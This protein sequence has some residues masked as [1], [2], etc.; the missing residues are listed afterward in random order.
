MQPFK[1]VKCLFKTI[2][3]FLKR[4]QMCK[5]SSYW[6]LNDSSKTSY[7]LITSKS[8][9][10]QYSFINNTVLQLSWKHTPVFSHK[11]WGCDE[12]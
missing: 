2:K 12:K 10:H 6:H 9:Y 7:K 1:Y 5:L 8:T 4:K 3:A 11:I